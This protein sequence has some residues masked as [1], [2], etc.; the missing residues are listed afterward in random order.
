MYLEKFDPEIAL[1]IENKKKRQME[2]VE[3]IPSGNC[4]K[5]SQAEGVWIAG[6][7]DQLIKVRK[8]PTPAHAHR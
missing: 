7:R 4:A 3:M 5:K 1:T 6:S 8:A 2:G